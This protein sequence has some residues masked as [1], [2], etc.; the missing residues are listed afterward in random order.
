M[1]IITT[2]FAWLLMT[3]YNLTGSYGLSLILFSLVVKLILLPFQMKSKRS[4]MRMTRLTPRVKALEKKYEG[5]RAKYNEEVAKLYREEKIKPMSGCLWS[6]IPFP[7]MLALYA[8]IRQP[9]TMLMKLTAEQITQVTE[10]LTSLGVNL[11]NAT[12]AYSELPIAQA[13]YNNFDAVHAVVPEVQRIDFNFLGINLAD[14]PKDHIFGLFSGDTSGG[15]W[16]II[17]MFLIPLLAG[18]LSWASMKLSAAMSPSTAEATGGSMKIMNWI[19]PLFSLYIG[20]V[21][22]AGMGI[23]WI[24]QSVFSIIQE[25]F[26]N[27]HYKKVLDAEDAV[28]LEKER[29]LEEER[30]RKREERERLRA[31]HKLTRDPNTS[32]RKRGK[33]ERQ[34]EAERLAKAK[35]AERK[36]KEADNPS[37]VGNRPYARGRAYVPDRYTNPAAVSRDLDAGEAEETPALETES[38]ALPEAGADAAAAPETSA[39]EPAATPVEDAPKADEAPVE[40]APAEAA[41]P[42]AEPATQVEAETAPETPATE[43]EADQ[44]P[45]TEEPSKEE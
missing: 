42:A 8:V 4:T 45:A 30:A 22:P 1:S 24:S 41:E 17:M 36:D 39:A 12:G 25:F 32:R 9:L 3:F 14:F 5:N 16:V 20:L 7:I 18:F 11:S 15:A 13:V 29:L 28:R 44:A 2:P 10:T 34:K 38:T 19:M 40:A 33:E 43:P 26:L 6:L 31:E 23:Y 37:R 27:R 21:M 35:A